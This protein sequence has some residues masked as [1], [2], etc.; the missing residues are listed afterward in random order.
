MLHWFQRLLPQ[1]RL[2]FPLF[3]RHASTLNLAAVALRSMLEGGEAV[4]QHCHE[5]MRR[6]EEA[7]AITREVLIGIRTTFITPFDRSDIAALSRSMDDAI[8]QMQK[9]AKA[10][11]LFEVTSFEPE[12]RAMADAIVEC[13]TLVERA[14]PL[15]SRIAKNAGD[16]SEI[17]VQITRI[18]GQGDEIHD[19]G[20]KALYHRSRHGDAMDFLRGQEV[21]GHLEAVIDCLDDVGNEIQSV[22]TEQV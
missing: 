15:L 12:M 10:I 19:R 22:V 5:V 20:L 6:E 1:E 4:S 13:S 17:C 14:V 21:Y 9:T 8:D 11:I 3:E 18:E 2:F 16:L 7:D